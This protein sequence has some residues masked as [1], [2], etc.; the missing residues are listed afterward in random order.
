MLANVFIL[1][2]STVKYLQ[3]IQMTNE[4]VTC[5]FARKVILHETGVMWP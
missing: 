3:L 4:T 2:F 1:L 5:Q